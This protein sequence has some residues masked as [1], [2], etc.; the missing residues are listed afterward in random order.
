MTIP[1]QKLGNSPIVLV[2]GCSS[3]IGLSVVQSLRKLGWR[4]FATARKESD[5]INLAEQGFESLLLDVSDSKSIAECVAEVLARTGGR[6]DALFNNAGFGVPGAVEDLSREAMRYQFE[7]NVFGAIELTNAVLPVMRRQGYG[8]ILFNSSVLGFA[9]MP[10]R[11]AY[12]ASKFALEGFVDTLRQELYGTQIDVC[13]IE[14]GPIASRFR[15]NAALQFLSW[16]RV[17]Q[18]FHALSYLAMQQRLAAV[19]ASVPFTLPASAVFDVVLAALQAKKPRARYRVTTPTKIFYYLKR[20]L[21]TRCLDR[22]L[23]AASGDE[24]GFSYGRKRQ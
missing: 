13:L 17:E 23:L 19:G 1:R 8:T 15:Q 6:L 12:N 9:A 11:G 2:S 4:V 5:V 21:P 7:T 18:S 3:G 24:P 22:I 20:L 10:Y 16:I 14:P